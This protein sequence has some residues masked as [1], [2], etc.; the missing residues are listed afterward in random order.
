MRAFS[1]ERWNRVPF[2][3]NE[4][5]KAARDRYRVRGGR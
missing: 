4:V 5:R 1:R 2:C 3:A